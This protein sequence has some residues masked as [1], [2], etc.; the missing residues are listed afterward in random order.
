MDENQIEKGGM[1]KML[2]AIAAIVALV[3]VGIAVVSNSGNNDDENNDASDDTTSQTE[4]DNEEEM[5]PTTNIVENAVSTPSLSTLVTAVTA[6]DLVDTLSGPGP[7]TVFAPD[8]DAFAALPA[9]TVENLLLPEN[10]DQLTSVLTFH[11]VPGKYTSESLSNGQ[12]LTTVNGQTLEVEKSAGSV[13]VNGAQISSAD[14]MSSNG[15]VHVISS[16][17]LPEASVDVGGAAMLPSNNIVEN[18]VKAPNLSTLVA[19]VTAADLV[20]TLSG[21]GPFTVFAP[22]D[23]AFSALPDGTVD[24]LL[25]PE[26]KDQ[27]TSVLTY[28]VVAGTYNAADITDGLTLETVN[29]QSLTFAVTDGVATVNGA[30]IETA[31]AVSSNGV[32]HVINTVLL[33]E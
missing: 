30:S 32:V 13:T 3:I 23:N 1:N 25:L 7:F 28:H 15:V 20:D 22:N 17:L 29:G 18:A 33:P 21:A 16:V 19:A 6:A 26:N 27:L 9:G 8:N 4:T 2:I 31:D 14:V 5:L 11:V 12:I 10:Q 24:T